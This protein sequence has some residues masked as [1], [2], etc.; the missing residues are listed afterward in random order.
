[1]QVSGC[2]FRFVYFQLDYVLHFEKSYP[3]ELSI[4]STSLKRKKQGKEIVPF[5]VHWAY[6]SFNE[7]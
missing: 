2:H 1:M 5:G 3:A 7:I 6:V 4:Q